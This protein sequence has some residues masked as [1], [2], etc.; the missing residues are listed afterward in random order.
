M[1]SSSMRPRRHQHRS[2]VS[3]ISMAGSVRSTRRWSCMNIVAEQFAEQ[4]F[5]PKAIAI[6]KKINRLAP[7]RLDIFERLGELYVE[8]GLMVEAK[9]QF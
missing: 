2:I 3:A 6:Y 1:K 4:G 9:S 7:Q 8:Q 5:L